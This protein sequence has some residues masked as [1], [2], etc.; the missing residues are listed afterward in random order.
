MENMQSTSVLLSCNK[1]VQFLI[2][3]F[4]TTL[5]Q[6]ENWDVWPVM[7]EWKVLDKSKQSLEAH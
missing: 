4:R 3:S 1:A 6:L 2:A 7:E 5:D